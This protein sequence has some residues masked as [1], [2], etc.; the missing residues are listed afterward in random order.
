MKTP[1]MIAVPVSDELVQVGPRH[2][3]GC[4]AAQHESRDVHDPG[5]D[6]QRVCRA[7]EA[8]CPAG[9]DAVGTSGGAGRSSTAVVPARE[10]PVAARDSGAGA[11]AARSARSP[12]RFDRSSTKTM[13]ASTYTAIAE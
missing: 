7:L 3:T 11:C 5:D 2:A 4:D 13:K 10:L 12:T 9:T 8:G 6:D 1:T